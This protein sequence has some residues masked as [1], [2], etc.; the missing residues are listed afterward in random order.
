MK[1][2]IK[3]LATVAALAAL[4]LSLAPLAALAF[5]AREQADDFGYGAPARLALQTGQGISGALLAAL[6]NVWHARQAWQG[7]FSAIFLFSLEPGNFGLYPAVPFIMISAVIFPIFLA[8]LSIKDADLCLCAIIASAISFVALQRLPS[9]GDGLF[10][11][12]SA[13]YYILFWS[14]AA[15]LTVLMARFSGKGIIALVLGA[16][17]IGGGNY[18]VA[19]VFPVICASFAIMAARK[20]PR[21]AAA[22]AAAGLL[23]LLSLFYSMS[24]PGNAI[25]AANYTGYQPMIAVFESFRQVLQDLAAMAV[26][27]VIGTL[28]L[29]VPLFLLATRKCGFS[30]DNPLALLVFSFCLVS[31]L[32][33]PPFYAMGYAGPARLRNI[34]WLSNLAFAFGNAFYLAGWA[35][36]V[37]SSSKA[38][39][40]AVLS[41][42]SEIQAILLLPGASLAW[43][44]PVASSNEY[45]TIE[46][47]AWLKHRDACATYAPSIARKSLPFERRIE[48]QMGLNKDRSQ[49]F[50][51]ALAVIGVAILGTS[52]ARSNS[53]SSLTAY[54]DLKSGAAEMFLMNRS[55]REEALD[56]ESRQMR[57]APLENFPQ[58]FSCNSYQTWSPMVVI[59]GNVANLPVMRSCG[60][61]VSY[62]E[63]DKLLQLTGDQDA[64][65]L[66]DFSSAWAV[67]GIKFVPIREF[68]VKLGFGIEYKSSVDTVLI[69]TYKKD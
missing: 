59:D 66:S 53:L 54:R 24:A 62:V 16:I 52:I 30:F 33:T 51:I 12:N 9:T 5:Y 13:S 18:C 26:L 69:E 46:G 8:L 23:G 58:S 25:R 2:A 68:C 41:A 43:P 55:L 28:L 29:C 11:W 4:A 3:P 37:F 17:F 6:N 1:K 49:F 31:A 45:L 56:D 40:K 61:E 21:A 65:A 64:A 38:Q 19:L 27:M 14:I 34:T 7:T 35:R 39:A 15:S 20:N 63:L 57:F 67:A 60:G 47:M 32:N 44:T 36:R 22:N 10:W 42:L 50:F 48:H